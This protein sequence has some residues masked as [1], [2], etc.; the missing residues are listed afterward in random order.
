LSEKI[1]LDYPDRLDIPH[2]SPHE[3][4]E[5]VH[6]IDTQRSPCEEGGRKMQEQTNE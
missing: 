6:N 2:K 1:T 5:K 4:E 3:R